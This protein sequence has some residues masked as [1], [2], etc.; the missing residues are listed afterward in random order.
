MWLLLVDERHGPLTRD[1]IT[2]D[3]GEVNKTSP[4][5]T[6]LWTLHCREVFERRNDRTIVG[7]AAVIT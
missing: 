1:T 6:K 2:G 5:F 3:P 4:I 7:L